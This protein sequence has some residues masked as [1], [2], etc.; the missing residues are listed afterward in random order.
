MATLSFKTE[1][2]W[3]KRTK[4]VGKIWQ[5]L[6]NDNSATEG[7]IG[8][9]LLDAND[10]QL[11]EFDFYK[12]ELLPKIHSIRKDPHDLWKPGRKIHMVIFNRTKNRFQFAPVLECKS[13]QRIEIKYGY[14]SKRVYVDRDQ[15]ELRYDELHEL[16]RNDGFNSVDDFFRFFNKDF[17]GKIIHWT[18]FLY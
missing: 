18:D 13:V 6:L 10:K 14:F 17:V 3:G 7:D 4:F 15:F 16:I 9:I 1:F 11:N 12:N 2:P 5:G 8:N